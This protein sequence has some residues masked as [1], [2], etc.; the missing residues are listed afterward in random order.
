MMTVEMRY[1]DQR[2]VGR[3]ILDAQKWDII[4]CQGGKLTL[5]VRA[6]SCFKLSVK[7]LRT[8]MGVNL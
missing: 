8:G 5:F 7:R 3:C 2:R 1:S 6:K 4:R